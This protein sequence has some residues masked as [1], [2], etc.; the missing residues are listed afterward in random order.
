MTTVELY[1]QY[2]LQMK[3]A[4]TLV[5]ASFGFLT[6]QWRIKSHQEGRV[7]SSFHTGLRHSAVGVEISTYALVHH[8]SLAPFC[9]SIKNKYIKNP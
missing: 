6:S 1:L 3:H 7:N 2:L 9:S 8:G 5:A 4:D